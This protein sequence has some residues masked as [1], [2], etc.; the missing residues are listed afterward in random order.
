[1][2]YCVFI[3]QPVG[4]HTP[5]PQIIGLN[6][7]RIRNSTNFYLYAWLRFFDVVLWSLVPQA[8]MVILN[9]SSI[10]DLQKTTL[11]I[12]GFKF[13]CREAVNRFLVPSI[14]LL[15][16]EDIKLISGTESGNAVLHMH[17]LMTMR[18]MRHA[19][20]LRG[21][22]KHGHSERVQRM[23]KFWTPIFYAGGS[24][25]YAN[26]L[27]ELL[28]NLTHDWP[29]ETAEVLRAGMF[30]NTQ[31]KRTTFKD[32]DFRV[33]Q[34]NSKGHCHSVNVRPVFDEDQRHHDHLI[35]SSIFDFSKDKKS[36]HL[37]VDLF[38]TGLHRL[39]G[40]QGGHAKHLDRHSLR[41]CLPIV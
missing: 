2:I 14:A 22:V 36:E 38:Q 1:M 7:S 24:Y 35:K 40:P 39:A 26:K 17:N 19:A 34:F 18:E 4:A 3:T 30:M 8:T 29:P 16:A 12:D 27:M 11:S 28:H 23:L 33:E 5:P 6:S 13:V 10:Q 32:T 21:S 25:N 15:E 9:V 37:V 31:G 41:R 20:V